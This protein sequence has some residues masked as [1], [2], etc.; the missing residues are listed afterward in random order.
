MQG[1][2]DVL[3]PDEAKVSFVQKKKENQLVK[4]GGTQEMIEEADA[5]GDGNVNYEEFVGMIYKLVG[6]GQILR[7]TFKQLF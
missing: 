7:K 3:S 2:G 6:T 4:K 1:V 5:D